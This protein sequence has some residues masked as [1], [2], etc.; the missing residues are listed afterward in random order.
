MNNDLLQ[1]DI[2]KELKKIRLSLEEIAKS[3]KTQKG[4]RS[5]ISAFHLL[6]QNTMKRIS[7]PSP[8]Q[9]IFR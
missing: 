9:K 1:K 3:M 7:T 2:I 8:I 6:L 5:T 4:L